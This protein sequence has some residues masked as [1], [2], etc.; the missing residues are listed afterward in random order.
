MSNGEKRDDAKTIAPKFD[1]QAFARESDRRLKQASVTIGRVSPVPGPPRGSMTV[2][3]AARTG[4]DLETDLEPNVIASTV[5]T[6]VTRAHVTELLTFPT[7][8]FLLSYIDGVRDIDALVL[9]SGLPRDL[10]VVTVSDLVRSGVVVLAQR[11]R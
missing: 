9:A 5:P 11:D 4:V 1:V 7:E 6:L 3:R 2:P 8:S 10:V